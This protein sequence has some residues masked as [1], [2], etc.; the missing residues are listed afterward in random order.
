MPPK[1]RRRFVRPLGKRRYR[2]MFVLATEGSKTESQYF[3]IFNDQNLVVHIKFLKE[4][5]GSAPPQVL[6]RMRNYLDSEDLESSDEAW[7]VVD[8]DQWTDDQLS[9]LH[10]WAQEADNY[11]FALSN[12]KFEF[13]LLLHFEDGRGVSNP[14]T[15]SQRLE[16]HIPGY[17]K[18]INVRKISEDTIKK[19]IERAKKRDT[20][21][22]RN[23]PRNTGT[24]VYRLVE[25]ILKSRSG[26]E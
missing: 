15:C 13:W 18:D 12:P 2:K 25:N 6:A 5:G 23:W 16:R 7:L 9:Q 14:R 1:K 4:K 11:G 3:S 8:K 20:P 26:E 17:D 19:A 24:T 21:A 22:C 10:E